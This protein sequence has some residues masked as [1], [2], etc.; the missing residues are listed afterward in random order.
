M[1]VMDEFKEEREA[2]KR[3]TFKE[4]LL[5]FWDY[6]K[7]HTIIAAALVVCGASLISA[8]LSHRDVAFCAVIINA[9]VMPPAEEYNRGFAEYANIDTSRY[10]IN[11][12]SNLHIR[13]TSP[14][15]QTLAAEQKLMVYIASQEIDVFMAEEDVMEMYA[16]NDIF[17]DL[18]DLLSEEQL[19]KYSPFF[20]YID[21]AVLEEMEEKRLTS[22]AG[23]AEYPDPRRPEAMREPV[24]VGLYLDNAAALKESY[25]F[26]GENPVAGVVVNTKRPEAASLYIDYI[27]QE[28]LP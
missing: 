4:K 9:A 2:L 28:P 17:Y 27:L 23:A 13:L 16:Y 26:S 25:V 18:R 11:F 10:D 20:Y 14:S 7:W 6:Y 1:P 21:R 24:P 3:G 5:Y 22:E 15:Q 19:S 12:D 8:M